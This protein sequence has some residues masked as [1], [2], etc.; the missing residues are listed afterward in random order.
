[1]KILLFFTMLFYYLPQVCQSKKKKESK[2]INRIVEN[3]RKLEFHGHENSL[4]WRSVTAVFVIS[5][6]A[7]GRK[8]YGTKFLPSRVDIRL[9][10]AFVVEHV[11]F[12]QRNAL[13]WLLVFFDDFTSTVA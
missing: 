6:H 8:H 11:I 12:K 4:L 13:Q 9:T 10:V 2:P 7:W 1:M 3:R 5:P